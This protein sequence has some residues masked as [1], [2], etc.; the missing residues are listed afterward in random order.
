[1]PIDDLHSLEEA[2]ATLPK[3]EPRAGLKQEMLASIM[4]EVRQTTPDPQ[5]NRF[6]L[7]S[8]G[9]S[10]AGAGVA[11]SCLLVIY[12]MVGVLPVG[13]RNSYRTGASDGNTDEQVA[14]EQQAY[15][16]EQRQERLLHQLIPTRDGRVVGEGVEITLTDRNSDQVRK[17]MLLGNDVESSYDVYHLIQDLY[18]NG[19]QLVEI[20]GVLVKPF[21]TVVTRGALTEIRER[22][23]ESPYTIKVIGDSEELNTALHNPNSVLKQMQ[24]SKEMDVKFAPNSQLSIDVKN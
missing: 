1:M 10:V 13:E 11:M 8:L 5:K 4:Q 16:K 23:V 12:L 14:K 2:I 7:P 3:R 15:I 22:R 19:G 24:A 6:R 21:T 18:E 9:F 20:N 17:G